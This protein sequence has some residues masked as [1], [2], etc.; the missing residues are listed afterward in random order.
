MTASSFHRASS[1]LAAA[2][3]AASLPILAAPST[4]FA[5]A[6]VFS[7]GSVLL[8]A[9]AKPPAEPA[10]DGRTI[11]VLRFTGS[12]AASELRATLQPSLEEAGFTV[13]GIALEL[14]EATKKVKCKGASD[15]DEC[16]AA[17]GKWLNANP[18]TAADFI[19]FG[20]VGEGNDVSLVMFDV[21]KGQRVATFDTRFNEGDLILPIVLP[22]ALVT[23]LQEHMT[24][25][26]PATEEELA[27]IAALDEPEKTPEEIAAEKEAI[28]AAEAAAAASQQD[29]VIDTDKIQAD[30]KE[31]FETFCR[32]EPRKKRESKDEPRDLRP[33]CKRGPFWG[34]WQPRA[35]VA[36]GLTSGAALGAAA[37]Y[38]MALVGRGPYGDAVDALDAYNTAVGGDP[39]RDPNLATNGD[40]SYDALAT[41][42]SRTG[43]IVRRRAIVGDVLLGTTVLLG[44]VLGIIIYQDRTDAKRFIKEE[45][46]IKAIS[47]VRVGP[48]LTRE[49]QGAG[50][51]FRF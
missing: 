28:A 14:G 46:S 42:V 35:W 4:A 5:A 39:R 32:N 43:A 31:D 11:G 12:P 22:Q 18:K 16:L 33:A 19:L 21:T 49:T 50:L 29:Q 20:R 27:A 26:P 36:L 30:L 44:G 1:L 9:P 45:K 40:Q 23:A 48:I 17:L 34:Y 25:P 13:R 6:P 3:L 7:S 38:T 10:T 47:D 41:E 2:S 15:S 8:A 51:S 24:P 37:M